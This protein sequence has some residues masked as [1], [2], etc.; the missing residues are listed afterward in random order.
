MKKNSLKFVTL[1][2]VVFL[3]ASIPSFSQ[4]ATGN[5]IF[6]HP[7]GTGLSTWNILRILKVGPDSNINWDKLPNIALYRSHTKNSITTS[8]NA[9]ATMHAFGVKA[10]YE[11]FGMENGEVV[12]ALSGKKMSIMQEAMQEKIK[13]GIVNSGSIFEPGTAVFVAPAEA[14]KLYS[15]IVQKVVQSGADVIMSGGEEWMLPDGEEGKF[16]KGKR[17]DKLNLI[18]WAKEN[19]YSVVFTRDEMLAL[20]NSTK[21]ILGVFASGHTFNE[22]TEEVLAENNLPYFVTT[23]P[24][25]SE[26]VQKAIEILSQDNNQ[27]F[28]IAEEESTDNFSNYNNASGTLE[29]LWR[30]DDAIGVAQNYLNKNPNTL[31]IVASDSEA[32]GMEA[33]GDLEK[34]IKRDM[35]LSTMKDNGAPIDGPTGKFSKPWISKPDKNGNTFPFYIGWASLEDGYGGVVVRANGMN[36][37]FCKGAFDNTD[38]YRIMYLTLFGKNL[39]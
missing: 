29:G 3:S 13:I 4:S 26:M 36:S 15:E 35:D 25:M 9:G 14:R 23:A 32:G 34:Y 37:N 28:L 27:F 19:G 1:F 39:W 10:N 11:S 8:S 20:P 17:L 2:A 31:V 22:E 6:L 33:I 38:I 21:K 30:A 18:N 12:T 5:V 24:K 7:D 16:G